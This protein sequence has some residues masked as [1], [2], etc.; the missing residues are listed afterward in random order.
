MDQRWA[1]VYSSCSGQSGAK[2]S[3]RDWGETVDNVAGEGEYHWMAGNFLKYGNHWN[4]MPVD[5]H[6]LIA[7]VAPRPILITGGTSDQWSDPHGEFLAAVAAGPVYRLLGKKDLGTSEMPAP[8]VALDAG[9]LAFREHNGGHTDMP[10][11]PVFLKF[12]KRYFEPPA[13]TK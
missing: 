8:D 10:D 7:M 3:R 5:S 2:L 1:I 12:A 6:E 13:A 11:W 9:E 4:D